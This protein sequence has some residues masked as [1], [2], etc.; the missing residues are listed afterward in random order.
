MKG[1]T[2]SVDN[3]GKEEKSRSSSSITKVKPREKDRNH[4]DEDESKD[5]KRDEEVHIIAKAPTKRKRGA[6]YTNV[7]IGD[8]GLRRSCRVKK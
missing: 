2:S 3:Q 4:D 1:S 5:E 6:T 7:D 8:T